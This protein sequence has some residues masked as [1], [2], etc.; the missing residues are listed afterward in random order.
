MRELIL[1]IENH[2]LKIEDQMNCLRQIW[3]TLEAHLQVHYHTVFLVL[4]AKLQ[5]SFDL[6][7]ARSRQAGVI[8]CGSTA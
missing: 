7:V 2:W 8:D 6:I 4:K 3:G 5:Q 1:I